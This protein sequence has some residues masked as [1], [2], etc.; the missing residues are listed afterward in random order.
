MSG[1]SASES[2]TQTASITITDNETAPTLSIATNDTSLGE[3]DSD[4]TLTATLSPNA[5]YGAV[6]VSIATT[7]TA[8]EGDDYANMADITIAAGSTTGTVAFNPIPDSLYDNATGT[9]TAI[10]NV[11]VSGGISN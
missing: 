1:G 3:G 10:I 2:G 11:G 6:T 7:G 9:E 8:D 5:T 4:A